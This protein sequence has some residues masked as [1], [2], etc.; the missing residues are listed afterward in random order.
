MINNSTSNFGS[1]FSDPIW[2]KLYE[3]HA[4]REGWER[5]HVKPQSRLRI[6]RPPVVDL[7]KDQITGKWQASVIIVGVDMAD[8]SDWTA[9]IFE[10]FTSHRVAVPYIPPAVPPFWLGGIPPSL[11]GI[12]N[13]PSGKKDD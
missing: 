6:R 13:P 5:D 10:K 3:A 12:Y 4:R 2:R 11:W 7:A 8:G 1:A 9:T